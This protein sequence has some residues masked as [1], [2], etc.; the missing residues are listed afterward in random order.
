ML[1]EISKMEQRYDAVLLVI[2]DGFSVAEA[3]RKVGVSRQQSL[4][5]V[6]ARHERLDTDPIEHP[7]LSSDEETVTHVSLTA[8]QERSLF[9]AYHDGIDVEELAVNVL[10]GPHD[11]ADRL[12]HSG[13]GPRARRRSRSSRPGDTVT[14]AR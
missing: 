10:T 7:L 11:N 1:K 13:T 5:V 6:R 8:R 12:R 2:R 3:S 4:R 14:S 9:D